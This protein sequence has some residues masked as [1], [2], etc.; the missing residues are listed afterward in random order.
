MMAAKKKIKINT[1]IEENSTEKKISKEIDSDKDNKKT[2][3][4]LK[5]MEARL[6]SL[7]K[8][9]KESY[10]RFL[11]V[12]AEFENY[13]KRAA[14]EMNDFRK[15]A[16]ESFI[17]AMLPVV[18]NLDRAIESSSNDD[19]AQNSVVEGV[20]MTLKEILKVFEQFNVK[21]F[22]SLGKAFDPALHQAVMQEE[23]DDHPENTILNELQKGY[24][25]HDRLL[26]PAMVVVSKT[27][28]SENQENEAQEE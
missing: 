16:N 27:T 18:D 4:P 10:D 9:A 11:R 26:R 2:G 5:E 25:M 14:R 20:N 23:T 24:M 6:E 17:K 28:E 8:E 13:K 22:E 15:F 3:D 19:H 7:E 1:E 12:S 21:P